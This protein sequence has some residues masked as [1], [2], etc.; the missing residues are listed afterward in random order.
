MPISNDL[1][2]WMRR[3]FPTVIEA[4]RTGSMLSSGKP[5]LACEP[6]TERTCPQVRL[7][8]RTGLLEMSASTLRLH[9]LEKQRTSP[10]PARRFGVYQAVVTIELIGEYALVFGWRKPF[11]I[12]NKNLRRQRAGRISEA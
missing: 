1:A 9:A 3:N 11:I 2:R 4:S 12:L 7:L 6:D 5:T 10:S 8:S